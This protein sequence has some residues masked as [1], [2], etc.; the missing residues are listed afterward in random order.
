[1]TAP[2]LFNG[3]IRSSDV[4]WLLKQ[5]LLLG[6]ADITNV[7]GRSIVDCVRSWL[8]DDSLAHHVLA[9]VLRGNS[10]WVVQ[11]S[12]WLKGAWQGADLNR[13][14]ALAGVLAS[15]SVKEGQVVASVLEAWMTFDESAFKFAKEVLPLSLIHI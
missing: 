1:M 3:L 9:S 15:S 7:P 4:R 6:L 8:D 11:L 5:G 10:T 2:E 13:K 12:E 14:H